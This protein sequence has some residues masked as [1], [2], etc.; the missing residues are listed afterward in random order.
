[1]LS[2]SFSF[3]LTA[4]ERTDPQVEECETT[5][6]GQ[7]EKQREQDLRGSIYQMADDF[8]SDNL[9]AI[10]KYSNG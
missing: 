6:R 2:C 1:M 5:E 4:A 9:T 10:E 3:I 7:R 8:S